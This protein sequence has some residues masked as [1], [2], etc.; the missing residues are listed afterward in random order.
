[1]DL[2]YSFSYIAYSKD[3]GRILSI[4]TKGNNVYLLVDKGERKKELSTG[5]KAA[6]S[7]KEETNTKKKDKNVEAS[8]SQ[9]QEKQEEDLK[10]KKTLVKKN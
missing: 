5:T 4:Y 2:K 7:K 3:E 1:L 9:K 6:K 8:K 10:D